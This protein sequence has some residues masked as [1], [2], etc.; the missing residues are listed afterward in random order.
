MRG[1]R[2]VTGDTT[3]EDL[4]RSLRE[5][6]CDGTLA[7]S[8]DDGSLLVLLRGGE[9]AATHRLGRFGSLD[10]PALAFHLERHGPSDLPTVQG[11]FPRSPV[12]LL[13]ALPLIGP[14]LDVP[15][16]VCDLRALIRDLRERAFTGCLTLAHREEGGAALF[17]GGQIAAAAFE[18]GG[19]VTERS[20][21]LRAV[22]RYS[23]A[24]GAPPLRLHRLEPTLARALAGLALGRRSR[25]AELASFTGLQAGESGYVFH[26]GGQPLLHVQGEASGAGGRFE[27]AEALPDLHL[28]DDPPG[29]E[30]GRYA[31]TL[32][33]RD[34]LNPMTELSM[35]FL[36]DFG[37]SGRRV[38][39]ALRGG[40]SIEE[41]AHRLGL[42]LDELKPWLAR[43]EQE[44]LIRARDGAPPG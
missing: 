29:W 31:L 1:V 38:L 7:L 24:E 17:V 43:L 26:L 21:A 16:A 3:G 14:G 5:L 35:R 4:L 36:A 9:V 22:Y 18:K 13:R 2:G 37:S 40:V 41:A 6:G 32:R 39:E 23:L 44:G 25:S 15:T 30:Q 8:D 11:A 33:G 20:D 12:A 10:A 42:E 27:E 19:V 28:P 34:A